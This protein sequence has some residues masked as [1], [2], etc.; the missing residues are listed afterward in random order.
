M[1]EGASPLWSLSEATTSGK[2]LHEGSIGLMTIGTF[3]VRACGME[4]GSVLQHRTKV[5]LRA[6][7]GNLGKP[8]GQGDSPYPIVVPGVV[9]AGAVG[10]CSTLLQEISV[11]PAWTGTAQGG[12][13]AC[14]KSTE[15]SDHL[16]VAWKPGNPGGA[17]GVTSWKVSNHA[18]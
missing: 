6:G 9:E 7:C 11:D 17:K 16:I 5:N 18:N 13:D 3:P 14:R 12:N 10:H 15:K 2:Q 1:I 4:A 8:A